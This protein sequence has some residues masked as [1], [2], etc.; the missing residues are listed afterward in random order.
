MEATELAVPMMDVENWLPLLVAVMVAMGVIVFIATVTAPDFSAAM[1]GEQVQEQEGIAFDLFDW[2]GWAPESNTVISWMGWLLYTLLWD[3]VYGLGFGSRQALTVGGFCTLAIVISHWLN[4]KH[5]MTDEAYL[6]TWS[7]S[8]LF[9]INNAKSIV[10]HRLSE[11][12][13]CLHPHSLDLALLY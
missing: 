13:S 11:Q 8:I 6:L 3:V 9:I 2:V 10:L 7:T 1:A 5:R 4:T 12:V